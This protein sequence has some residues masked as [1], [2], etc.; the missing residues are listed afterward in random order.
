MV[1]TLS[2]IFTLVTLVVLGQAS[3]MRDCDRQRDRRRDRY[4]HCL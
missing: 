4:R 2:Y 1:P 3:H